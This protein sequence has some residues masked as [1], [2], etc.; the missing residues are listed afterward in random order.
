MRCW[1]RAHMEIVAISCSGGCE[2]GNPAGEFRAG[3]RTKPALA[4]WAA[5]N[6]RAAKKLGYTLDE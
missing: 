5:C 2:R 3:K 6:G 4:G 1:M